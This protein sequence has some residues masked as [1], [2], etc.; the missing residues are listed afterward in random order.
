[1]TIDTT[2][3]W[4]GPGDVRE[5]MRLRRVMWESLGY[6]VTGADDA[7]CVEILSA[8]LATGAF[9]A[10][11]IDAP[12][13]AGLASC[14]VGMT[15]RRLPGPGNPSG[16]FGYIQSMVTDERWRG[17]GLARS[18]LAA[19]LD[20]FLADGV[21]RVDLHASSAGEPLYRSIGFA[22]GRQPELRWV[23]PV[24]GSEE[25]GSEDVGSEEVGS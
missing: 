9:F 22:P 12:D 4:A 23:A 25:V 8:G 13:G 6:E 14:G 19:L 16:R 10:S 7:A 24:P 21:V 1:M 18:V 15:A 5:L 20:R 3:R 11:V 2:V 17:Q